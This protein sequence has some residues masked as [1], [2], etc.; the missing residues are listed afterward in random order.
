MSLSECFNSSAV[1]PILGSSFDTKLPQDAVHGVEVSQGAECCKGRKDHRQAASLVLRDRRG[2]VQPH[3]LELL[4]IVG[5]RGLARRHAVEVMIDV[6]PTVCARRSQLERILQQTDIASFNQ[7]GFTAAA[8]QE[9]SIEA[10]RELLR[11]GPH[12]VIVTRGKQGALAVTKDEAAEHPGFE[13]PVVDTTG[14]GDTF[15]AAYL[16][17]A[18][19]GESLAARLRLANAT[20]AMS[21][22]AL[23]PRGWLPTNAEVE[24]FLEENKTD[25]KSNYLKLKN[26]DAELLSAI[27]WKIE[28]VYMEGQ[29]RVSR[30]RCQNIWINPSS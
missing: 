1:S 22:T 18:L 13:V 29:S 12:T 28:V 25:G 27:F 16:A 11:F 21:V 7:F 26:I 30:S 24:F 2:G 20:A 3:R 9:P 8:G 5:H 23:G 19:R 10:A 15:H 14:A 6:E 17:A 4:G